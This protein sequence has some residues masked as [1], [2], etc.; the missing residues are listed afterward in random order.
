MAA[1]G[2]M[3]LILVQRIDQHC[4]RRCYVLVGDK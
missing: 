4:V 1:L 2:S 3:F